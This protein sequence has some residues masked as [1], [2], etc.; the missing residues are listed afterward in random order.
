MIRFTIMNVTTK[1]EG[2]SDP[3]A[4]Q[5]R[6]PRLNSFTDYRQYLREFYEFRR[7]QTRTHLRPYSYATFAAAADIKSPNYLKLIIDGQRNLSTEMAKRFS[8]ALG[9]SRDEMEE[10]VALVDYSQAVEPLERNRFLK[11]LADLR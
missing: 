6:P 7:N 11:A 3:L 8:R 2:D 10:F 4:D 5:K 1:V 9:H